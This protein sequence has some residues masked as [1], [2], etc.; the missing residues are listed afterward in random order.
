MNF[1][2]TYLLA[3]AKLRTDLVTEVV[4]NHRMLDN[5]HQ[6]S[7]TIIGNNQT[8]YGHY[9]H[10]TTRPKSRRTPG[11]MVGSDGGQAIPG[12]QRRHRRQPRGRSPTW[13]STGALG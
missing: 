3:D 13:T 6:V 1:T 2:G 8:Q 9:W 10:P 7:A 5:T 12:Q 4:P 11:N